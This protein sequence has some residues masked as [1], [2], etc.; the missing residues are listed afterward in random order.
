MDVI[1]KLLSCSAIDQL[2]LECIRKL[3]RLHRE[4]GLVAQGKSS[5]DVD[6]HPGTKACFGCKCVTRAAYSRDMFSKTNHADFRYTARCN[7]LTIRVQF[8]GLLD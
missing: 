1:E 7:R 3:K 5:R 2:S 6:L 4:K 8:Y